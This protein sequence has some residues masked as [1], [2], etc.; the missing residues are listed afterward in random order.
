MIKSYL[1]Q[2][3]TLYR[4]QGRDGHGKKIFDVGTVVKVRW[5]GKRTTTRQL[6]G[7]YVIAESTVYL[8]EP[9]T[10]ND[11]FNYKG[12]DYV[13]ISVSEQLDLNGKASHWEVLT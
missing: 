2:T 7:E 1:T 3:A 10:I 9:V 5:T 12:K 6:N 11:K 13:F 4:S 8:L